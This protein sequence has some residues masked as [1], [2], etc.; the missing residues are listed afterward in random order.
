MDYSHSQEPDD[1]RLSPSAPSC[2]G[3]VYKAENLRAIAMPLGGIG[4]GTVSLCGNGALRQWQIH[5]QINHMAHIPHSFFAVWARQFRPPSE[6]QA[7]LLQC[8]LLHEN[9]GTL[10]PSSNDHWV[11]PGELALMRQ[12]PGIQSV[13]F[14]GAYP[15]AKMKFRDESL[16]LGITMEA[17]SPFCPLD[18]T[19]SGLPCIV[20]II[21]VTNTHCHT[22]LFSVAATLQNA[23]GW[24]GL[25]PIC[26]TACSL[27]GGNY[28]V[29]S[30]LGG[31]TAIDMGSAVLSEDSDRYGTMTLATVSP[32]ATYQTQ[33]ADLEE[34]WADFS[35]DGRL[36]NATAR[37]P[38]LAGQTWNGA[39]AVPGLL[40][41]GESAT[42]TFIMSW[43]F[44]NRF[45]NW[46]QQKFG[47]EDERSKFWLG[48]QY[49]R[50][51]RS[52]LDIANHVQLNRE[53]LTRMTRLACETFNNTT[54][55]RPLIDA[56]TSQMSVI[57]TPTCFWTDDGNFWGFEGCCGASTLH[58]DPVGGCCPLNC[59]HVWNYEMA[60]ARLFPTLERTMRQTEWKV[61]QHPIGYLPHRV[62]LP[63]Y[64]P[65]LWDRK[66]GGP[67]NP[68]IDGLLGGVLKTYREF[69][70]DGDIDWLSAM[71]PLVKKALLY[72]WTAHD[73]VRGGVIEG[74][75]PCTYDASI[76]GAN[77]FIG[78]L[79]L[80]ALRAGEAMAGLLGDD[81]LADDCREVFVRGRA[82]LDE[83]LWNGE[84]YIHDAS[85]AELP[86]SGWGIG[87][88]SDQLV[89]QWWAHILGL[90][91]LLDEN[92]VRQAALSIFRHNFRES[93][94]GHTQ[95][96]RVFAA[97][98][99]GGLLNCTWPR[100][101][102]PQIP[103]PYSDEIW[104]GIEYEV[105]ALLLYQGDVEPAMQIIRAVRNRHDGRTQNP[106]NDIEC[107]DHYVRA[108]SSWS[109]LEAASGYA[110]EA[111]AAELSFA[112]LFTPEAFQAPFVTRDGWGV[113]TQRVERG[114]QNEALLLEYGELTLKR[115]HFRTGV[116]VRSAVVR[117]GVETIAC[118]VS[119]ET[120]KVTVSL[121]RPVT[122]KS[123]QLLEITFVACQNSL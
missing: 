5:N 106:W 62:V 72:V 22:V 74:E 1:S 53:D 52:A 80:A 113:F 97:D 49:N 120:D 82:A 11:P 94:H 114:S 77:T 16:P 88:H 3:E 84:Y 63:Q 57:R 35:F 56:V 67:D 38:S 103:L 37:G 93:M 45:V 64:L 102:R 81:D 70:A 123:G 44:P 31:M 95:E 91:Y 118:V 40:E 54:L 117:R 104:T 101:G 33:W 116:D 24:D 51:F 13:E 30:R 58:C 87:C 20:F 110:Y 119:K 23:V 73:P 68:A 65:R 85:A 48:N 28:N 50:W 83:R 100:G 32:D 10:V 47:V 12:L 98:T 4:T 79:Y 75:Q 105:A 6:P 42:L 121:K 34:F 115:L 41:P 55:P 26:G 60:L 71:M 90:G 78:T 108:M 86:E 61:Q 2:Y 19:S 122:L 107:G 109:L 21:V 99:D 7:R 15:I 59:T 43:H 39:L 111:N 76:Y 96:P 66:I 9:V 29:L 25:S 69:R 36:N 27:Y 18:A 14:I 112:P 92:H 8:A 17:F 46:S 89:G